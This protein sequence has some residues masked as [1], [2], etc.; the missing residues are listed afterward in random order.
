MPSCNPPLSR[1][2][3]RT[4]T[5]FV[6]IALVLTLAPGANAQQ[7]NLN[8]RAVGGVSIDPA[9]MTT[10]AALDDLGKLQQLRQK[11]MGDVPTGLDEA[12]DMRRVSM[13]RLDEA[14]RQARESGKPIPAEIQY[15]GGLQRIQY[16]VVY[17][18][19]ND[20]VLVGPAEGWRIDQRGFPVGATTGR[21][22]ML[23][24]DLIVAL[25]AAAGPQR[26]VITC[27]IDPTPEG[28]QRLSAH[29][30]QLRTIGNPRT[31]AMGVEQQ[32][33]PQAVSVTGVPDT[34]HFARVM[35]AADYR[36][37]RISMETE[38]AP[39]RGL[40][41]FL[42][43]MRASGRGMRNM[44]P[45]WWLAPG[46]DP[47]LRDADGLTWELRGASVQ[48]LTEN[49]FLDAS[50]SRQQTGRADPVSEK[51]AELMSERYDDLALADPVFGQLQNCMDLAIVAALIVQEN[52]TAKADVRLPMLMDSS[53]LPAAE[54]NAPKQVESKATLA[55]KGRNW[56]IACGGVEINAW[57]MVGKAEQTDT[58]S[59]V[60]GKAA[61]QSDGDRWWD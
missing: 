3:T 26:S 57:A 42:G 19:K 10:T 4:I 12:T 37:K 25:R 15:L 49:D 20:I 6:V 30:K 21:P 38:P 23:F 44:L 54:F 34:S 52:L 8:T 1:A 32:L 35:V 7:Q 40:P 50:G 39:I 59:A 16:V 58:L 36:M 24:D 29:T 13:R 55:K 61:I 56:M 33:G 48:T 46:Y 28:L 43:M 2:A 22:P 11:I 31:T 18:E 14:A 27:S 60:R 53:G 47:I 51:W 5:A 41:G 9:G 17:P 45:R